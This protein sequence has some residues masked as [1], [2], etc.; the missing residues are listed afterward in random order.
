MGLFLAAKNAIKL[1]Y[2]KCYFGGVLFL[3]IFA[4]R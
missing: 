2:S 3:F 4:A 1:A